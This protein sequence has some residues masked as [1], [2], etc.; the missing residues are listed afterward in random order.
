MLARATCLSA[1]F[2]PS[3]FDFHEYSGW[4]SAAQL[5]CDEVSDEILLRRRTGAASVR[6]VRHD[7][8]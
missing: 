3:S 4:V 7:G 1:V 5:E 2:Q 8:Q 6:D